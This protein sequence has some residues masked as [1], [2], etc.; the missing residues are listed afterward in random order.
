MA[1]QVVDL[2]FELPNPYGIGLVAASIRQELVLD[3]R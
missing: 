2:G 1:Q 3:S